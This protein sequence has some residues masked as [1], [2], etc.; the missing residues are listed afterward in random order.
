MDFLTVQLQNMRNT[1]KSTYLY[2]KNIQILQMFEPAGVAEGDSIEH[3][4]AVVKK[5][6]IY[7]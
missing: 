4:S 2:S 1:W 3:P 5:Q 7:C 6:E